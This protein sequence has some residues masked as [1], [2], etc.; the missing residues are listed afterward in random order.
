MTLPVTIDDAIMDPHL[1]GAGF[2]DPDSWQ[3]WRAVL[4]AAFGL[5]LTVE[6]VNAFASIAGGR[7]PPAK[8]VAELW[9]VLGRRSGKSRV[10]AALAVYLAVLVDHTGKLAP[11]EVGF[12]V[13]LAATK[14]QAK[15]IFSYCEGFL[16][17]SPVL[18]SAIQDVTAEE[19]RLHGGITISIQP[20]N[21]R[22]IRGKTLLA[23]IF[24][25]TSFW[26]SEES[27]SPDLEVYRAVMPALATTGGMLISIS[28]P[29]RKIGLLHAKH[30]A[31]FGVD[32]GAVLVIQGESKAFNPTL[33][34][35]VISRA[36][37]D[38]PT[39]ALSEWGGMFRS[40][41]SQFLDDDT[42]D[43]AIDHE[44][45]L[46][47]PPRDEHKYRCF[48]D[49]SAGRHDAFCIG[50][51]HREGDR[52]I[53]D[54]VRGRKPPFDPATVAIE[55]AILAK[56]YRCPEVVGDAFAGEWV[57]AAFR[58][59]G[60]T[61]RRADKPKSQLYLE[62]LPV[63]TRGQAS[64]PDQPQLIR[65]MRLL[66]RRVHRSGR[67]T[68]DHGSGGSDD[69]VNVAFGAFN[70]IAAPIETP[71]ALFGH[72]CSTG[73]TI[74]SQPKRKIQDGLIETGILAGGN[75]VSR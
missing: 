10:A 22:T 23:A 29:Y 70:L 36:M 45:P 30:K 16:R 58:S 69:F 56:Q 5:G 20:A 46:E 68:V 6:E 17:A 51:A 1:L 26:R 13:V 65:E 62:G 47:L 38:D 55:F 31:S 66:E 64:I 19:I 41:L 7:E 32:D 42:I 44:R 11:G 49:A 43:A 74:H 60:V 24:D 28:S 61:Y 50:I 54:V 59:A 2:G 34:D 15:V 3:M 9:A 21:Y 63:F 71:V 12:V 52:I 75:A 48:V 37:A 4:R 72:Y 18:A 53:A 35:D 8:R 27:A 33:A 67:D 57:A 14:D 40:D 73:I 39:S 25:E